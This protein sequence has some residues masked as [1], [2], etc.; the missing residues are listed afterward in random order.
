MIEITKK[1]KL[2]L[3]FKIQR[4]MSSGKLT[5]ILGE[6]KIINFISKT[7]IWRKNFNET[8]K[9]VV[10]HD[11]FTYGTQIESITI[12]FDYDPDLSIEEDYKKIGL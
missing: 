6:P 2:E 8:Q 4:L 1:C 5:K 7:T 9:I 12:I 11:V 3:P 10:S